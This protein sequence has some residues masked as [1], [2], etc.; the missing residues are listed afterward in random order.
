MAEDKYWYYKNRKITT[1]ADSKFAT[2][3]DP[4]IQNI[5]KDIA[6]ASVSGGYLC[7]YCLAIDFVESMTYQYD[8]DYN[9]NIDYTK[10]AIETIVDERGD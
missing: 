1:S 5:A 2:S 10:N 8:I 4:V 3:H 7:K 6:D 9:S